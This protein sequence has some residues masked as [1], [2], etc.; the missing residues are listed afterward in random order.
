VAS[1]TAARYEV[2]ARLNQDIAYL[3]ETQVRRSNLS[4][5]RHRRRSQ[6]FFFGMLAAQLGVIIATVAIAARRRNLLW[7]LASAAGL[8]AIAFAG[9]V[10]VYV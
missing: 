4:A 5:D 10:Y 8:V 1:R 9:Y 3:L 6:R 7:S 2:E